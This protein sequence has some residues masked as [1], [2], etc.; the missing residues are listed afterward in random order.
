MA[1]AANVLTTEVS[2]IEISAGSVSVNSAVYFASDLTTSDSRT[3]SSLLTENTTS[4]FYSFG[5][6]YGTSSTSQAQAFLLADTG[7]PDTTCITTQRE[8][9]AGGVLMVEAESSLGSTTLTWTIDTAEQCNTQTNTCDITFCGFTVGTWTLKGKLSEGVEVISTITGDVIV[10]DSPTKAPITSGPTS[11]PTVTTVPPTITPPSP[12]PPHAP[13]PSPPPLSPSPPPAPFALPQGLSCPPPWMTFVELEYDDVEDY[14]EPPDTSPPQIYLL[15]P[16]NLIPQSSQDIREAWN[17]VAVVDP[18]KWPSAACP[19]N[20]TTVIC[21]TCVESDSSASGYSCLC[22]DEDE[23][24]AE[25]GSDGAVVLVADAVP[26][27]LT[28][29]TG[30]SG[31][32]LMFNGDRILLHC[33]YVNAWWIEPGFSASDNV[34]GDVTTQVTTY[35]THALVDTSVATPEDD[36]YVIEYDVKDAAGNRAGVVRRRIYVIDPCAAD[37]EV[38]CS[39]ATGECSVNQL[40]A[41]GADAVDPR[42]SE[43]PELALVGP[44]LITVNLGDYYVPCGKYY[45]AGAVCDSG[46]TATDSLDGDLTE[47]VTVCETET[48]TNRYSVRGLNG[49]LLDTQTPGLYNLTFAVTNSA[50]LRTVAVRQVLVM[51]SCISY[52]RRCSSLLA[53]SVNGVCQEDLQGGGESAVPAENIPPNLTLVE[54]G[55]TLQYINIKRYY[56]YALCGYNVTSTVD[57]P[58]DP[59]VDAHDAEDGNLTSNVIACP[60]Y[61]STPVECEVHKLSVKGIAGCVDTT[62]EVDTQFTIEFEVCDN[63]V[64]NLCSKVYRYV[65]ITNPCEVTGEVWCGGVDGACSPVS[66][67]DRQTLLDLTSSRRRLLQA[68]RVKPKDVQLVATGLRDGYAALQDSLS[69]LAETVGKGGEGASVWTNQLVDAWASSLESEMANQANLLSSIEQAVENQGAIVEAL[70]LQNEAL[71]ATETAMA[72]AGAQQSALL[73]STSELT[74]AAVQGLSIDGDSIPDDHAS[75]PPPGS[76]CSPD[77]AGRTFFFDVPSILLLAPDA[78]STSAEEGAATPPSP[79]ADSLPGRRL[80]EEDPETMGAPRHLLRKGGGGG[81]SAASRYLVRGA[82]RLVGGMMLVAHRVP[83][84]HRVTELKAAGKQCTD[85]FESLNAPCTKIAQP[86]RRTKIGSYGSDPVF[87]ADSSLYDASAVQNGNLYYDTA[88]GSGKVRTS[89][90]PYFPYPFEER[91]EAGMAHDAY[92]VWIDTALIANRASQLRYLMEEGLY[93]DSACIGLTATA[94]TYQATLRLF[95]VQQMEFAWRQSGTIVVEYTA[96]Y[97]PVPLVS[98][99]HFATIIT[100]AWAVVTVLFMFFYV[101]KWLIETQEYFRFHG[102]V[103]LSVL[104]SRLMGKTRLWGLQGVVV[105][106]WYVYQHY[107]QDLAVPMEYDILDELYKPANYLM[108]SKQDGIGTANGDVVIDDA[109]VP[110]W[111]LPNDE[112]G[113][114]RSGCTPSLPASRASPPAGSGPDHCHPIASRFARIPPAGSGPD[115]CH[116][117]IFNYG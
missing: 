46:A 64:P 99:W 11:S 92:P 35:G 16:Q 108:P 109:Q 87:L 69:Q 76:F 93:L 97:I 90:S 37:G 32:P 102:H 23:I 113:M 38:V 28:L 106:V 103:D 110:R 4:V 54:A 111:A 85:R 21:E 41:S 117:I 61:C 50:G 77:L 47:R 20:G 14:E 96:S 30:E 56:I 70:E 45:P 107:T 104:N 80:L 74:D 57:F 71:V 60:P 22:L 68:D 101:V 44:E 15:G 40:C 98:S 19:G 65:T 55:A 6:T 83:S 12:P 3:F 75:P 27:S 91:T 31:V 33:L 62:A 94:V 81:G 82:N 2:I 63:G 84:V 116:P 49:C 67:E 1:E 5:S 43:P 88:H 66:C 72:A 29:E 89:I 13:P 59:G 100:L 24:V 39:A 112:T 17:Q 25:E 114:T 10:W 115:H 42:S 7:D 52:E 78:P 8:G 58:C 105:L 51:I 48:E 73:A 36:P 95:T 53:C 9:Q 34:D 18:C 79:R 26:P 86:P